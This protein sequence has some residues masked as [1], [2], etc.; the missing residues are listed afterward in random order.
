MR[1]AHVYKD[2]C[3]PIRGGIERYV[4]DV[5]AA[6][7]ARGHS[8]DVHVAGVRRARSDHLVPGVTVH[9]HREVA[10]VL[11]SPITLELPLAVCKLDADVV[12]LHMPNPAGEIG[13]VLNTRAGGFVATFHAPV[14]RQRFLEP[15]YGRLREHLLGRCHTVLVSSRQLAVAREL[16]NHI[17]A[18]RVLPYGV[19]PSLT[20][21]SEPSRTSDGTALRILFVGRLVYYKGLDVL[22]HAVARVTEEPTLLSIVGAGP[23]RAE[24]EELASALGVQHRVEFLGA[25][26]DVALRDLYQVHDVFV[27]PSGSRAE[28]FGIA[29]CEA[30]AH[31]L[32]AISTSVGTGTDW[33]NLDG[34]TGLVVPPA[35]PE[36][37]A[38]ALR[39][40]ARD[41]ELRARFAHAAQQRVRREFSFERHVDGLVEVYNAVA[42]SRRA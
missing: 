35:D 38:A 40:L 1:I 14:V 42:G 27:M 30:M 22:L 6:T 19:S 41:T 5:A 25:V 37:L 10:R 15:A 3:P 24:L 23:L 4:A 20:T 2:L 26:D 18:V 36:A 12:H 9:R 31:G 13:A 34:V 33:V 32:C 17:D 7:A 28:T 21:P 39:R 11:S 16:A 8:V 29:M